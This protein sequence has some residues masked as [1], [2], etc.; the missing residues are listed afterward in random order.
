L[1]ASQNLVD[2]E[3]CKILIEKVF[4]PEKDIQTYVIEAV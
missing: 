4:D 2:Y 1:P 3:M